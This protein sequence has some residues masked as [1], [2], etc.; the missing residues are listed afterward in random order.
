M[1]GSWC[2][3]KRSCTGGHYRKKEDF[4]QQHHEDGTCESGEGPEVLHGRPLEGPRPQ[5]A[6]GEPPRQEGGTHGGG[7]DTCGRCAAHPEARA[8]QVVANQIDQGRKKGGQHR[9]DPVLLRECKLRGHRTY[10][11]HRCTECANLQV[12][13]REGHH[14]PAGAEQADGAH[15][16]AEQQGTLDQASGRREG[17]GVRAG[18][19]ELGALLAPKEIES[20]CVEECEQVRSA[21]EYSS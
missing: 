14:G 6:A 11:V 5:A 15:G 1:S 7:E 8:E 3:A 12:H 13:D 16:G 19:V 4:H 2:S 20:C 10:T 17:Q 9:R 18:P 21:I